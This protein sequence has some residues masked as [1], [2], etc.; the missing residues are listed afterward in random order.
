[1]VPNG[2]DA[3]TIPE[4][5][6]HDHRRFGAR[7]IAAAVVLVLGGI[8]LAASLAHIP[9]GHVGVL[10]LFGRV[11]DEVLSEGIHFVNPLKRNYRMSVRTRELQEIASPHNANRIACPKTSGRW[12]EW[13]K[14]SRRERSL[15]KNSPRTLRNLQPKSYNSGRT[16]F[17]YVLDF[18]GS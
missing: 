15:G 8:V 4:F 16:Q 18:F 9:P 17:L 7:A 1:M 10:T 2:R 3:G 11:T 12:G 14:R 5:H 6:R 13:E